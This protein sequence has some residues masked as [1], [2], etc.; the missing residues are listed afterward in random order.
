MMN[1][2]GDF[3]L[4]CSLQVITSIGT[5][6]FVTPWFGVAV[7]PLGL[8]YFRILNYFRDVSRETKRLDSIARSPVFAHFSEVSFIQSLSMLVDAKLIIFSFW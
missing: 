4:F 5:I 2:I 7:L 3:F 8:L 1:N 6:L